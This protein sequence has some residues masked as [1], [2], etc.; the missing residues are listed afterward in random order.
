MN[1]VDQDKKI[2]RIDKEELK[3][4]IKTIGLPTELRIVKSRRGV[5]SGYYD[6]AEALAK[7]VEFI[8]ENQG[9]YGKIETIY[10]T[11]NSFAPD[12]LARAYDRFEINAK[13][14][15]TDKDI[16]ARKWLLIDCD[17]QRPTGISATEGEH[18]IS[19]QK[20]REIKNYLS[21]LGFPSP[22]VG[23][24]GNGGHLLYRIDLPNTQEVTDTIQALLGTLADKFDNEKVK[25]DRSVF[26]PARIC[27]L[28]GTFASKGDQVGDRKHRLA[29]ILEMPEQIAILGLDTIRSVIDKKIVVVKEEEGLQSSPA[30]IENLLDEWQVE[31]GEVE[32]YKSGWKWDI[33]VCPFCGESDHSAIVTLQDGKRGFKCHHNRCADNHWQEFRGLFEGKEEELL[34]QAELQVETIVGLT[35]KECEDFYKQSKKEQPKT[36]PKEKSDKK[37][38]QTQLLIKLAEGLAELWH[39]VDLTPYA[40]VR[41]D[42]HTE[43]IP[44]KSATFRRWLVSEYYNRA[45]N[46]PNEKAI[47]S[48]IEIIE[49][50]AISGKCHKVYLRLARVGDIIYWDLGNTK[51]ETIKISADGWETIKNSPVKFRR[52]KET[53]P[54]PYPVA[55][56]LE[57]LRPLVNATED[58]WLLLKGFLLDSLK[59]EAPYFILSVNG[60]HGSAKSATLKL[61]RSIIDPVKT[62]PLSALPSD[63]K[64][65]GVDAQAEYMLVYDNVSYIKDWLSDALCRVSTGAGIKSRRLYTDDEQFVIGVSNPIALNGIPDFAERGDLLSRSLLVTQETIPL[66][67]RILGKE[68]DDNFKN[69]LPQL[70]GS[71]CQLAVNGLTNLDNT[72]IPLPRMADSS[73]W[74][75]ACLG[76]NSFLDAYF[77][78]QAEAVEIGLDA[79]PT[80]RLLRSVLIDMGDRFLDAGW[81]GS[82]QQLLDLIRIQGQISG[83]YNLPKSPK[84]LI[85]GLRRDAPLLRSAW[86]I[87]V[88]FVKTRTTRLVVI[89][90]VNN[91]G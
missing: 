18:E 9:N 27:K 68:L 8:V 53:A 5:I 49:H 44:I 59:A 32:D 7:D 3:K 38:N 43:N 69:I 82:A 21:L 60:E 62:A 36:Q 51:W 77:L 16:T 31:H 28:Y 41:I 14:T 13:I 37:L 63:E 61:L 65:L 23:D 22:L 30:E 25:V 6:D 1:I 2:N 55:G 19:L 47:K 24:S 58:N 57:L 80:A 12:L 91:K 86:R 83:E 90:R 54:L 67:R 75:T 73:K 35:D 39:A 81:E 89:K 66:E 42:S 20:T 33:K 56:S 50:K 72:K 40:S 76:D 4:Y 87:D 74:V 71:L 29:K 15:T 88:Q 52:T 48:A 64:N 79:S 46:P 45:D 34:Y 84:G 11:L 85:N 10:T 70:I 17:P 78:N 26:N